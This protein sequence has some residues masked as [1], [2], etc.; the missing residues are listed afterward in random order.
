MT[1]VKPLLSL[2]IASAILLVGAAPAAAATFTVNDAGDLPDLA[3]DGTCEAS[4]G[5]GDCT[6]RAAIDEANASPLDADLISFT[7]ALG[8][9]SPSPIGF[10]ITGPVTID[11]NGSGPGAGNTIVDGGDLVQLFSVASTATTATFTDLRLQNAFLD[12]RAGAAGAALRTD[13]AVTLLDGVVVTENAIDGL[14]DG[15]GAGVFAGNS[16]GTL[17]V[18]DSVVSANTIASDGNNNGA[19]ISSDAALAITA[20]TVSGNQITDGTAA[21]GGG[22]LANAGFSVLRSTLSGNSAVVP[23]ATGGAVG[24]GGALFGGANPG[25]R[26]IAA[27][28]ISG[29]AA[30]DSGGGIELNGDASVT[31]ITGVTFLGNSGATIGQDLYS[32]GGIATA[33]NSIFGSTGACG[34]GNGTIEAQSPGTNIDV[35]TTC[36]FNGSEN[37]VNTIP[38]LGFAGRQRRADAYPRAARGQ[39]GDRHDQ[40]RLRRA[41]ARSTL[42]HA[43]AGHA[44]RRGRGRGAVQAVDGEQGRLGRRHDQFRAHRHQLRRGLHGELFAGGL[45]DADG[46]PVPGL[47]A[48]FLERMRQHQR[49]SVHGRARQLRERVRPHGERELRAGVARAAGRGPAWGHAAGQEEVQEGPKAEEG[50][51]REEEAQDA[52][53]PP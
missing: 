53:S 44:L 32:D 29:N 50:Q 21:Q 40:R 43:A 48:R 10:S 14:G 7:G 33:K 23:G 3:V 6:L 19:G 28:T 31:S 34:E 46:D 38:V 45:G 37:Q 35:G 30:A 1:R 16:T 17:T 15:R 8:A 51:V 12:A 18:E 11:G 52:L 39:P 9:I 5:A 42:D 24:E 25:I 36:G 2:C 47:G 27:S 13:A 49:R 20:T 22:V 26:T 4:A 41:R